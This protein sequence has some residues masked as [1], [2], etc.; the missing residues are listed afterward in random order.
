[1]MTTERRSRRTRCSSE[2]A[3]Q[4]LWSYRLSVRT[5]GFHPGKRGSIPRSSSKFSQWSLAQRRTKVR[6]QN[7]Q[8]YGCVGK[9]VTPADCKSAAPGTTCSTQVTST[10]LVKK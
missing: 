9:L 6:L 3:L 8:V 4:K 5:P 1:M 7:G 10:N 2:P